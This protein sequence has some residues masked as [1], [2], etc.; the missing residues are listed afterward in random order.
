MYRTYKNCR[1]IYEEKTMQ[2]IKKITAL[3]MIILLAITLT[4]CSSSDNS[5]SLPKI[6]ADDDVNAVVENGI[7]SVTYP[8]NLVLTDVTVDN[9]RIWLTDGK[10][11][12]S[13]SE[14][15]NKIKISTDK[16]S[17]KTSAFE[18]YSVLLSVFDSDT[19]SYSVTWH[20]EDFTS[21]KVILEQTGNLEMSEITPYCDQGN[22]DFVN[23][24]VFYNLDSSA[25]Y[26]YKILD[27]DD[28]VLYTSSFTT[29]EESPNELTFMHISDTQDEEFNGEVWKKLMLDAYSH[30]DNLDFIIHTGDM[31]QYGG[32][33]ELWKN[34]LG[35]VS[36]YV[37]SVPT[38]LTSGNHSYWSDYTKGYSNIEYNHTTVNLPQQNEKN[39]IYYSFDVGDVHFCILSSGDSNSDGVGKKQREWLEND[40]ASTDKKWKIVAIH[41]PLY[42][43]GKYGSSKDRNKIARS[44]QKKL[45]KIFNEYSVDLVLE[46]HDHAFALTRPMSEKA[47]PVDCDIETRTVNGCQAEFL[48][49]PS[50]PVYLM[51]AAGGNQNREVVSTYEASWFLAA[52]S[53]PDN[54]AGYSII[55]VSG[56][57]LTATFYEY[58][59]DNSSITA[60]V[61]WGIEKS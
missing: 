20:T 27:S 34:M 38:I 21:S 9:S 14:S 53:V 59:Y 41:N 47:E 33:E 36:G 44:Q 16:I 35:N 1:S 12:L 25:E 23:R 3:I 51:S 31:V 32:D 61:S 37:S 42:S 29:F 18:V 55:T 2:K 5:K 40:L 54:N 15:S 28:N 56:N 10:Y 4:N 48:I 17:S 22:G 58:N 30:T 57:T 8:N 45:G 7:L 46:G 13:N 50:A 11:N 43:P 60:T 26:A 49:N 19:N 6:S 24:A 52:Q 39:G